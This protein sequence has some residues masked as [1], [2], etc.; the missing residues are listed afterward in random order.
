[1]RKEQNYD[2]KQQKSYC[3]PP[4][5]RIP[6]SKIILTTLLAFSLIF[7]LSLTACGN[8]ST[9]GEGGGGSDGDGSAITITATITNDNPPIDT[10]AGLNFGFVETS[11][12]NK[13]ITD[14]IKNAVVTVK[15]DNLTM[16]LGTP[17]N[18]A[19]AT[20]N[21]AP[22]GITVSNKAAKVFSTGS[23]FYTQDRKYNLRYAEDNPLGYFPGYVVLYYADSDVKISGYYTDSSETFTYDLDLKKGW[24]YVI[25]NLSNDNYNWSYKSSASAPS[26]YSWIIHDRS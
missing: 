13:P 21:N 26:N 7:T 23:D 14:Y 3:P 11:E 24:N 8:G 2:K 15:D 25:T 6:L 22:T 12:G 1:M 4:P 19:T 9:G 17:V 18:I 10:S 16:K 20:V 5:R